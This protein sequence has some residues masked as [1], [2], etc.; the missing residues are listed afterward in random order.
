MSREDPSRQVR[1]AAVWVLHHAKGNAAPPPDDP[2]ATP[3]KLGRQTKPHY[4]ADAFR[5][6]I[7]G[8][9]LVE[10]L[11]DEAGRV[12]HAEVRESIPALD[13]AAVATIRQWQ[14][15]PGQS[16]GKPIITLAQAPVTFRLH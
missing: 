9:V 10:F 16:G 4:P 7:Q 5:K 14:F 11:I 2:S 12:V 1:I 6:R 3:P 15:E 8:T 13:A